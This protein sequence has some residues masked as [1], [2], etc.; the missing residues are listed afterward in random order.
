MGL[1][2]C[3]FVIESLYLAIANLQAFCEMRE[4]KCQLFAANF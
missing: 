1:K 3:F 4:F 2:F